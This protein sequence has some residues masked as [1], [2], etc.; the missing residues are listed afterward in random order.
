MNKNNKKDVKKLNFNVNITK[1]KH[2]NCLFVELPNNISKY[3]HLS[4]IN[5]LGNKNLFA[6]GDKKYSCYQI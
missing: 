6:F 5:R 3:P 4:N 1:E 2:N